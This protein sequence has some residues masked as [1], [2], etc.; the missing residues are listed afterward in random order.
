MASLIN[1]ENASSPVE[2]IVSDINGIQ[3]FLCPD[4]SNYIANNL[5]KEGTTQLLKSA[6]NWKESSPTESQ[7]AKSAMLHGTTAPKLCYSKNGEYV[8][9]TTSESVIF[10]KIGEEVD[11]TNSIQVKNVDFVDISPLGTYFITWSRLYKGEKGPNLRIWRVADRSLVIEMVMV[12]QPADEAWPVIKFSADESIAA[13][14][15]TNEIHFYANCNFTDGPTNKLRLKG[16][17][18]FSISPGPPP[19]RIACF[20]PGKKGQPGRANMYRFGN[21]DNVIASKSFFRAEDCVFRWSP[22]GATV[23][24]ETRSSVDATGQSYMG[25]SNLYLL[26]D[27]PGGSVEIKVPRTKDGPLHAVAWSP[28]GKE[29]AVI[30]GKMP[31]NVTLHN[32]KTGDPIFELGAAPRNTLSYSPQGRFLL[33]GGFGTLSGDMDFWDIYKRKKMGTR[34]SEMPAV[35][36]GWSANGRWFQIAS[37]YP[38]RQVRVCV[39]FSSFFFL[40]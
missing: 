23:L 37:T 6:L 38:R 29:F 3:S 28:V 10:Q 26:S 27:R 21:L 2:L 31:P 16:I 22:N 35:D 39:F 25:E 15:V 14:A 1:P 12:K 7:S 24:V 4:E 33:V 18:F 36:Y 11:T 40:F 20:T 19:Q 34:R 5:S 8:A 32:P 30:A 17:R 13:R 9:I